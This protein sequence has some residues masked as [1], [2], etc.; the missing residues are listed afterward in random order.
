MLLTTVPDGGWFLPRLLGTHPYGLRQEMYE[1]E[2]NCLNSGHMRH[3]YA[4]G[5][6][7]VIVSLCRVMELYRVTII[8]F[9]SLSVS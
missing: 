1:S 3:N 8:R 7:G 2:I 5:L 6:Y 9:M 4:S